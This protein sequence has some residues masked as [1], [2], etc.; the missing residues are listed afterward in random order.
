MSERF[1]TRL[2]VGVLP[3]YSIIAKRIHSGDDNATRAMYTPK[4]TSVR[5]L[6]SARP[7][8][9]RRSDAAVAETVSVVPEANAASNT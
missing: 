4:G 2:W 7:A 8:S 9:A 3:T 5:T 1:L 6:G